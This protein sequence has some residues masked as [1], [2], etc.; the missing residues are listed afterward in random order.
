MD[1]RHGSLQSSAS[2]AGIRTGL[3]RI[4]F[5]FFFKHKGI[6]KPERKYSGMEEVH[7]CS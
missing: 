1:W 5:F 6:E 7:I 3:N 2:S 4:H